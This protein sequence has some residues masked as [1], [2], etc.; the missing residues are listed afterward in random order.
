MKQRTIQ[1][2]WFLGIA[3][4]LALLLLLIPL[5]RQH[6]E[7]EQWHPLAVGK[8]AAVHV[9]RAFYRRPGSDELFVHVRITNT[10]ERGLGV[11][12]TDA[13]SPVTFFEATASTAFQ[14]RGAIL[15]SV[16]PASVA[17]NN[18]DKSILRRYRAGGLTPLP[19]GGT[20]S[21]FGKYKY[22][23]S[24]AL[25]SQTSAVSPLTLPSMD[26]AV[27]ATDGSTVETLSYMLWTNPAGGTPVNNLV[28]FIPNPVP[29]KELPAHA[30]VLNLKPA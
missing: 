7:R 23:W 24:K 28:V 14:L 21:Y 13:V 9:E 2:R 1:V 8:L 20:I 6:R 18:D 27:P 29:W 15:A 12:L 10:A 22:P 4:P 26:G 3:L 19:S 17:R 5:V 25:E 30:H 11:S 16:P